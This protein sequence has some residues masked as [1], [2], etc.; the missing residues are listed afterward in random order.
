MAA[1]EATAKALEAVTVSKTKELKGV[2]YPAMSQ[3]QILN[4]VT[5]RQ[6]RQIDRCRKEVSDEMAGRWHLSAQCA[7]NKRNPSEQHFCGRCAREASQILWNDGIPIHERHFT[8]R[9]Q[10]FGLED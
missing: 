5:D 9:S 6:K 3:V 2:G 10:L 7:N 8:R 1:V 4:L